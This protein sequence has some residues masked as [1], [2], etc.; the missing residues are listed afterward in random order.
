MDPNILTFCRGMLNQALTMGGVPLVYVMN[1][2]T[3]KHITELSAD[4]AA[5]HMSAAQRLLLKL[6]KK[7]LSLQVLFG[8]PIIEN[9][10]LIDG[11]VSLQ[12]VPGTMRPTPQM[13]Q[14]ARE[15]GIAVHD[16]EAPANAPANP[17]PAQSWFTEKRKAHL[18]G[19]ETA[20]SLQDL[21]AGEG[22]ITCSD[23]LMKAFEGVEKVKHV[24][25]LRIYHNGDIDAS[26]NMDNTT[27][28]G[29]IQ[30]FQV[31]VHQQGGF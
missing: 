27:L 17:D 28:T 2:N 15:Q 23:I 5:P 25:V 9:N 11:F 1:R 19:E 7:Q 26:S 16:T 21:S 12:V 14:A 6:R 30:K 20:P 10:Y 29:A 18:Q 4:F 24:A 22:G 13:Q 31:W 3:R 8:V